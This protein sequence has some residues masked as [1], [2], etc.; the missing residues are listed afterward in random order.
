MNS[1]R[2]STGALIKWGTLAALAIALVVLWRPGC[3]Y[4]PPITS[5]EGMNL[6]KLLYAAC[7]ARDLERLTMAEEKFNQLNQQEKLTSREKAAFESII[8]LARE[9]KWEQ[10]EKA[11]F[12]FAED[13]LGRGHPAPSQHD[14]SHDHH[15]H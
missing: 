9:K 14:H 11:S 5:P 13:Q 12:R 8:S 3:K 4:Y 2:E 10:A 15:N 1:D 6:V 7:N